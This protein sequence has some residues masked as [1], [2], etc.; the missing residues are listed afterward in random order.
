MIKG[1]YPP[2]GISSMFAASAEERS[3]DEPRPTCPKA[4]SRSKVN[5]KTQPAKEALP[6]L[7]QQ[8]PSLAAVLV[9]RPLFSHTRVLGNIPSQ[10]TLTGKEFPGHVAQLGHGRALNGKKGTVE[11]DVIA[12]EITTHIPDPITDGLPAQR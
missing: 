10:Q 12:S 11:A 3:H 5:K 8:P 2:D 7:C 1:I 9:S 6:R 4:S